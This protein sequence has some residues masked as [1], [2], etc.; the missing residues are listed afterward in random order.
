MRLAPEELTP[1][2]ISGTVTF[3]LISLEEI[4]AIHI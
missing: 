2:T 4:K 3:E 1:V